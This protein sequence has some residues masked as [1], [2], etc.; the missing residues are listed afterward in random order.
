MNTR[1]SPSPSN[2][3]VGFIVL[4]RKLS[5]SDSVT[6][7]NTCPVKSLR[8]ISFFLYRQNSFFTVFCVNMPLLSYTLPLKDFYKYGCDDSTAENKTY[9]TWVHFFVKIHFLFLYEMMEALCL[10][11]FNLCHHLRKP[12]VADL[13]EVLLSTNHRPRLGSAHFR[14]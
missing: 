4:A 1:F 6:R 13:Q 5:W 9:Q 7:Y 8:F 3:S 11:R 2:F 14:H 10:E 12:H